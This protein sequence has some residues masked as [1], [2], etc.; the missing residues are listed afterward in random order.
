M[1]LFCF[2]LDF[3]YLCSHYNI[4]PNTMHRIT[5][6]YRHAAAPARHSEAGRVRPS[7]AVRAERFLP[8]FIRLHR[9]PMPFRCRRKA[10]SGASVA[11]ESYAPSQPLLRVHTIVFII[12][13]KFNN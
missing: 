8:P 10:V 13:N 11:A 7:L 4:Y 5:L 12:N 6:T 1:N 3:M 2:A 9:Q